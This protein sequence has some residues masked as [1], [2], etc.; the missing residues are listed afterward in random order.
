ME[1]TFAYQPLA[2]VLTK[3]TVHACN[4]INLTIGLQ[5]NV[6]TM[7]VIK[8]TIKKKVRFE[9]FLIKARLFSRMLQ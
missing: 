3:S 2:V 8:M 1:S 4:K 9:M 5:L 7:R 6:T